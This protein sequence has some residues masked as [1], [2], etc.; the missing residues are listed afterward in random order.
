VYADGGYYGWRLSE[1]QGG[2]SILLALLIP[3]STAVFSFIKPILPNQLDISV[4]NDLRLGQAGVVGLV[5]GFCS[6][7][8]LF[9]IEKYQR[10][11]A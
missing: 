3:S 11:L 9:S 8:F 10:I 6:D 1:R 2:G 4:D 5:G 7:M